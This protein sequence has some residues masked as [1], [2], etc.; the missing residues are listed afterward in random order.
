VLR[1]VRKPKKETD[2]FS[3]WMAIHALYHDNQLQRAVFYEAEFRNLYQGDLSITDYCA[4]L[5]SLADNLR[6]IGQPVSEP[7][8]VLNLLRGLNPKYRHAISAI[9]SRHPPHTFLSARSHLLM[10]ELF[11]TQRATTIAHHALLAKQG[12][13]SQH[14]APPAPPTGNKNAAGSSGR[15]NGGG[16][17]G[18]TGGTGGG[19]GGGGYKKNSGAGA[20]VPALAPPVVRRAA[21]PP[22]PLLH[23]GGR[24][25]IHG[26]EWCRPGPCRSGLLA[27]EFLGLAQ[28]FSLTRPCTLGLGQMISARDLLPP[29]TPRHC[30]LL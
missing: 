20:L 11:D 15:G 10:E 25:S 26:L 23:T 4:K 14:S 7:S 27:L 8:Q 30:S 17:G 24:R 19:G 1:I 18:P 13:S 5:K 12:T 22:V 16:S 2:A 21:L 9:T 3:L 28:D 29:S 6:D